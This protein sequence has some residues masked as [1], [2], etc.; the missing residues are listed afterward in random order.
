M[1]HSPAM[2]PVTLPMYCFGVASNRSE[3][4]CVLIRGIAIPPISTVT[5]HNKKPVAIAKIT[6]LAASSM[7]PINMQKNLPKKRVI[8]GRKKRF[9]LK[10]QHQMM[11]Q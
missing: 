5:E 2:P 10:Y 4:R 6:K 11:N 3:T 8:S 9:Q 1:V 7:F